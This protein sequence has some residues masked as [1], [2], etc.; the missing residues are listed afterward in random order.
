MKWTPADIQRVRDHV[1]PVLQNVRRCQAQ[2]SADQA[3]QCHPVTP[4]SDRFR[5]AFYREGAVSVHVPVAFR[6]CPPR[7]ENDLCRR[8]ELRYQ[9]VDRGSSGRWCHTSV[10]SGSR[11]TCGCASG[12]RCFISKT[13]IIG[14]TRMNKRNENVKKP[15]VPTKIA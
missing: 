7:R 8:I 5:Q 3:D 1:D 11:G 13:E 6:V 9:A 10:S 4:E 14:S 12:N 2:Q 15:S